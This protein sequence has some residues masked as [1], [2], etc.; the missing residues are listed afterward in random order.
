MADKD[1]EKGG[2]EKVLEGFSQL[3]LAFFTLALE[4]SRDSGG[5]GA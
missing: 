4:H 1:W 5:G 3:S 2:F